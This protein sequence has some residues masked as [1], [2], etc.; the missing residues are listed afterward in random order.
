MWIVFIVLFCLIAATLIF[1][2]TFRDELMDEEERKQ[3]LA[4]VIGIEEGKRRTAKL[5]RR[6]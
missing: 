5:H 3:K 6:A 2:V 4:K 1:G